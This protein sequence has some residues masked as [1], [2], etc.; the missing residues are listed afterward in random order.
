MNPWKEMLISSSKGLKTGYGAVLKIVKRLFSEKTIMLVSKQKIRTF[1]I[2]PAFQSVAVGIALIALSYLTYSAQ[3]VRLMR[4]KSQEISQL[5]A[6]NE[7]FQE[8]FVKMSEKLKHIN[9]YLIITTGSGSK[10]SSKPINT[11]ESKQQKELKEGKISKSDLNTIDKIN[12]DY[13]IFA[14]VDSTIENRVQKFESALTTAGLSIKKTLSKNKVLSE[15]EKLTGIYPDTASNEILLNKPEEL[16]KHQG[17]PY[18]KFD[19]TRFNIGSTSARS[20]ME[21]GDRNFLNRLDYLI[22]LESLSKVLPLKRPMNNYYI[23]SGFGTRIDP[24]TK[25][26]LVHHGLDFVGQKNERVIS[27]SFGK[28]ILA[29][30]Y[31]EYGNAI[32]IDHGFGITTRYG[33]LSKIL[34][35]EG[36]MVKVGE[37]IGVQGSTGRSTGNHLHYEV[38]YKSKPIDPRK[39]LTAGA[40]IF[41]QSDTSHAL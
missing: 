7:Y 21:E 19:R 17:G 33:H 25:E 12:N 10:A 18:I 4:I 32:I 29:Q 41:S 39:F 6:S 35:K 23:S 38:R 2:T 24:I 3:Y 9:E 13:V 1:R 20:L 37:I 28:V 26:L 5:K 36:Q 16:A 11:P 30:R 14:E 27:P 15:V 22:T 8:E 34:V 40:I 31:N